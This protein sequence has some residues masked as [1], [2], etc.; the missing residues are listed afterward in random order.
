METLPQM[1][2]V[3]WGVLAGMATGIAT[4]AVSVYLMRARKNNI[5]ALTRK[6]SA[7]TKAI[8]SEELR[9]LVEVLKDEIRRLRDLLVESNEE[10]G[11]LT[12]LLVK[13]QVELAR[14]KAGES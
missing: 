7:E 12:G 6:L 5:G 10:V 9:D 1:T 4:V 14:E 13:A 11:K 3:G 2:L 8:S